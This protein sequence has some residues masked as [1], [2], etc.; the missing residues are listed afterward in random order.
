MEQ[1]LIVD[2][3][4]AIFAWTELRELH[5]R[6]PSMARRELIAMLTHYQDA[7]GGHVVLVFDGKGRKTDREGGKEGGILVIYSRNGETVDTV[8]ERIVARKSGR[9]RITVASNDRAELDT[10]SV[11]GGECI[12]LKTLR[13]MVESASSDQ[14]RKW[15]Y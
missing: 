6:N 11:F 13:E 8:I 15:D 3:H 4:S 5:D 1:V 14:R 7:V 10:V 12:G 2:G 9:M